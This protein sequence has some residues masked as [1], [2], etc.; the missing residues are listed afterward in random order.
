MANVK[1]FA[2]VDLLLVHGEADDNVHYQHSAI[3]MKTLQD[4]EIQFKAMA[5]FT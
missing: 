5:S 1:N 2:A 4:K 3:L